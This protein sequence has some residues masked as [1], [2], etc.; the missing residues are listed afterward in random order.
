V[1]ELDRA[2]FDFLD[3]DTL[4]P[5]RIPRKDLGHGI[6]H[7]RDQFQI[8]ASMNG[9]AFGYWNPRVSPHG[10]SS[11]TLS[12]EGAVTEYK[13]DDP[14]HVVPGPN[15]QTVFTSEGIFSNQLKPVPDSEQGFFLP[16]HGGDYFFRIQP[17]PPRNLIP[18][19]GSRLV[20]YRRGERQ[21][22]MA[23]EDFDAGL[24]PVKEQDPTRVDRHRDVGT[25]DKRLFVFPERKLLVS[26]P[27]GNG[28]IVWQ[29]MTGPHPQ[30]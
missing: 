11:M 18:A 13:H 27:H 21:P 1:R 2:W 19:E 30:E 23:V 16:A 5:L 7:Q 29:R 15:G 26:I 8:R 3:L 24:G 9:R 28:R 6:Q 22:V 25:Y 4:Q 12:E 20:I 10:L 14:A 17:P